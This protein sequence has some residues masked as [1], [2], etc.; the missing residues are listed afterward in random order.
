VPQQL[1]IGL[2]A[3]GLVLAIARVALPALPLRMIASPVSRVQ[4]LA[5]LL[6][7]VGLLLHCGAMFDRAAV[8]V[9]PGSGGYIQIVNAM[10]GVSVVLYVIPAALLLIGLRRLHPAAVA[11]LSVAL[12]AVGVT[13][14]DRGPLGVHLVAIFSTGVLLAAILA[15]LVGSPRRPIPGSS[16]GRHAPL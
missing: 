2:I 3:I 6:G 13:M 11:A 14:Y 15:L 12:V 7:L 4:S 1:V 9:L 8:A 10:G 5:V 16:G